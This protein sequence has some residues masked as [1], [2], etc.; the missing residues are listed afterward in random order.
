M[1]D[2]WETVGMSD[3]GPGDRVRYRDYEFTI[4]RVDRAFLGRDAMV[5]LIE[6]EPTRFVPGEGRPDRGAAVVM[7]QTWH[8]ATSVS[9]TPPSY[10]RRGTRRWCSLRSTRR[11]ALLDAPPKRSSRV[12]ADRLRRASTASRVRRRWHADDADV[13]VI[14]ALGFAPVPIGPR[15]GG[16]GGVGAG[17]AERLPPRCSRIRPGQGADPAVGSFM[18]LFADSLSG[19]RR[20]ARGDVGDRPV[21]PGRYVPWAESKPR[22]AG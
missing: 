17:G 20:R 14:Q 4:A 21:G 7:S 11:R 15:W 6:D 22:S 5:C 12:R 10:Y 1:S 16:H 18:K 13:G 3:V 8:G 19:E 9:T 2:T